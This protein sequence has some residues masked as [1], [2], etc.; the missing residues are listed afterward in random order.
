MVIDKCISLFLIGIMCIGS[1]YAQQV[2]YVKL[3]GDTYSINMIKGWVP[4]TGEILN[5]QPSR[6]KI[7]GYE[8]TCIS[9]ICPDYDISISIT[10]FKKCKFYKQIQKRDSLGFVNSKKQ[11][12][13]VCWSLPKKG[14]VKR[15]VDFTYNPVKH[16]ETGKMETLRIKRWYIQGKENIYLV[17]FASTVASAWNQWLPEMTK[18]LESFQEE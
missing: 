15:T 6:R 9:R 7:A 4:S 12:C 13:S 16:L 5:K 14:K 17:D 2:K 11:L 8:T 3:H 1:V 18:L 10:E